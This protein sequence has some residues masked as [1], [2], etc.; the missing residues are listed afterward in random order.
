MRWGPSLLFAV[1]VLAA[2]AGVWTGSGA[3]HRVSGAL[4]GLGLGGAL[5]WWGARELR[6]GGIRARSHRVSRWTAPRLFWLL[7]LLKRGLPGAGMLLAGLWLLV[8]PG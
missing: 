2:A 7:F 4:F 1:A 3:G 6:E 5:L 8:R